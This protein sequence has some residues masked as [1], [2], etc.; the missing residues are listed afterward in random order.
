MPGKTVSSEAPLGVFNAAFLATV[1]GLVGLGQQ[2]L[3]QFKR[4]G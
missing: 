2:Y 1:L 3:S 4:V